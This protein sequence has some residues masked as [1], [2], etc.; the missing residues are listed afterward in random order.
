ATTVHNHHKKT[1]L[2]LCMLEY[3]VL[4]RLLAASHVHRSPLPLCLEP[5]SAT[6]LPFV[7]NQIQEQGRPRKKKEQGRRKSTF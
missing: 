5:F 4:T 2:Q 7:E 1:G 6:L 3:F